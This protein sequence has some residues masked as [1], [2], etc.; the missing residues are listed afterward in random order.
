M[1]QTGIRVENLS[2]RY[3]LGARR[4]G[5]RTLRETI[6]GWASSSMARWK[7]AVARPSARLPGH[8]S[9]NGHV[10]EAAENDLW[11]LRGV[12][13]EVEQGD[14]VG[15]IGRNGAG[16]STLLKVLSR[17]T[18]PTEGDVWITGRVSSLLEVGTGFHTELTGREN[19]YLNGAILGMGR[20]EV[21]RKFDEIVAFAE[22]ERFLDTPVKHYSSGMY[23]R[24]AFAVAAHLEPDILIIDEVLA[25]GDA[26]FQNKCLGKMQNVARGGRTVLFVS[27]NMAAVQA[28]CH[29]TLLLYR[30]TVEAFGPTGEVVRQY[31]DS[32]HAAGNDAEPFAACE[33]YG[34]GGARVERAYLMD[35]EGKRRQAFTSGEPFTIRMT[36]RTHQRAQ[37]WHASL[38]LRT[39]DQQVVA[40]V[41]TADLGLTLPALVPGLTEVDIRVSSLRLI[42]GTYWLGCG[43]LDGGGEVADFI[44]DGLRLEILQTPVYGSRAL[45]H[46][47]GVVVPDWNVQVRPAEAGRR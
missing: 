29:H 22:V 18:E 46:R 40:A 34:C 11:A 41:T 39:T 6:S 37:S 17:I 2:K 8:E 20:N 43:V 33:R 35:D 28:L 1:T 23:M 15:I 10:V 19:I 45:D 5:S 47:W 30:G 12:S 24:L 25:V 44:E 32:M 27:H 4:V 21:K 3:R 38:G 7:R 16:K 13:F 36:I 26:A 42:P 31:S 9:L 14:V